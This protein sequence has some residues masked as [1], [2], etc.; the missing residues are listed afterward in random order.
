MKKTS[1]FCFTT[2][3][4]CQNTNKQ[5]QLDRNI[6]AETRTMWVQSDGLIVVVTHSQAQLRTSE[7]SVQ[8]PAKPAVLFFPFF[9]PCRDLAWPLKDLIRIWQFGSG[10]YVFFFMALLVSFAW[11]DRTKELQTEKNG[12]RGGKCLQLAVESIAGEISRLSQ[13]KFSLAKLPRRARSCRNKP[14]IYLSF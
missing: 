6:H 5:Q 7:S 2:C 10:F 14:K 4:F 12:W 11:R 9:F 13:K 8:N 3:P 1:C